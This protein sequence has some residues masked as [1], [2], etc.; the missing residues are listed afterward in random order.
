MFNDVLLGAPKRL[1]TKDLT[2]DAQNVDRIGDGRG[3][4]GLYCLRWTEP[5][6]SDGLDISKYLIAKGFK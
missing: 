2:E 5:P 3:R 4:H 1:I 6:A